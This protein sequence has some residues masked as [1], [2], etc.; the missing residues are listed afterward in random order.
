MPLEESIKVSVDKL[1]E[2]RKPKLE[3]NNLIKLMKIATSNVQF[4]F[5]NI[6]Y[7]QIDGVAMG[8]PLG[9]TLA[10]IFVGYLESKIAKVFSSQIIYIRYVDDC[11][12]ISKTVNDNETIFEKLNSLREKIFFTREVEENNQ[13]PFLDILITKDKTKF[14]MKIYRKTTF[15]LQY[16]HYQS[17]CRK[18]QKVNLMKTLYHRAYNIC[19]KKLLD[20][21]VENIKDIL[22]KN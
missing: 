22:I 7:S 4:S 21:E 19:F 16:L 20:S 14:L 10:N 13:L 6:V 8:S 1:Y 17:F 5:N 11:L 9:Q 15:T 2:L 18:K 3:K 12:V